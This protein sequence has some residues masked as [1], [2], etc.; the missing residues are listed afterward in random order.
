MLRSTFDGLEFAFECFKSRSNSS[1][2][3]SSV[4]N[5]VEMFTICIRIP[6][7]WFEFAIECYK[8]LSNATNPFRMVRLASNASWMF[9]IWF[10]MLWTPFK[11]FQFGLNG[12]NLH[13]NALN[14]FQMVRICIRMFRIC[15]SVLW[16]PFKCFKCLH[17]NDFWMVRI[18]IW[19]LQILFKCFQFGLNTSKPFRT[20]WICVR[21]PFEWLEF[22]IE[23]FESLSNGLNLH[24]NASRMFWI[25]ISVLWIPFECF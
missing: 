18:C 11:C 22:A 6:F 5:L 13:S 8:S 25:C 21:M 4:S 17:S 7:E 2:L 1:N 12:Y 16:I 10:W 23:C 9:R 19:M 15:I 24:S 3:H 14:P 20:V